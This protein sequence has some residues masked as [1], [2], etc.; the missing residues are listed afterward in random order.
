[1]KYYEIYYEEKLIIPMFILLYCIAIFASSFIL[2]AV[3]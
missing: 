3:K 2:S 1:M